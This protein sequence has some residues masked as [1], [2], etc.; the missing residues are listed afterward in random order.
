MILLGL[1]SACVEPPSGS[2]MDPSDLGADMRLDPDMSEV[3]DEDMTGNPADLGDLDEG[4]LG[5]AIGSVEILAPTVPFA[6]ETTE[7][8]AFS[9]SLQVRDT[10]GLLVENY[11]PEVSVLD[12]LVAEVTSEDDGEYTLLAIAPG[13][14]KLIITVG[15]IEASL[16]ITV[17][18]QQLA[19]IQFKQS[20][21][22]LFYD[23]Q[24]SILEEA[25]VIAL[26]EKDLPI[27]PFP[28]TACTLAIEVGNPRVLGVFTQPLG[29]TL[30][31][32]GISSW[33]ARCSNKPELS[34][35]SMVLVE[36]PQQLDAMRSHSCMR[37]DDEKVRCWGLNDHGQIGDG[38]FKDALAPTLIKTFE[39][40]DV[41]PQNISVGARHTCAISQDGDLYC[42][43]DNRFGQVDPTSDETSFPNPTL[44]SP[45]E[46]FVSVA[47]GDT[48]SCAISTRGELFC[49][50][51]GEQGQLGLGNLERAETLKKVS[52]SRFLRLDAGPT[53][54]CAISF[55]NQL[56][57][58]GDDLDGKLGNSAASS[59]NTP[60][61]I[62]AKDD[63][64][65]AVRFA[66]VAVG[67]VT[68]CAVPV[69]VDSNAP[70]A[71]YCWGRGDLF[72]NGLGN[73][74][75]SPPTPVDAD[76]PQL[77]SWRENSMG[78]GE[79]IRGV[80]V[81]LHHG[82]ALRGTKIYCW[83]SGNHG[84]L[85]LGDYGTG[86]TLIG[87]NALITPTPRRLTDVGNPM[88]DFSSVD[89]LAI[90]TGTYHSCALT[91]TE[92]LICW[93]FAGNG[94]L[95]DGKTGIEPF[96]GD[97]PSYAAPVQGMAPGREHLCLHTNS[98][99]IFC[100][101]NNFYLQSRDTPNN[102]FLVN[103]SMTASQSGVDG[104]IFSGFNPGRIYAGERF[105]IALAEGTNTPVYAW[106]ANGRYE[107]SPTR[108]S[109]Y[110]L[111][112]AHP[113]V[114]PNFRNMV[115]PITAGYAHVCGLEKMNDQSLV[116]SCWGDNSIGQLGSAKSSN[117]I[118]PVVGLP[119]DFVTLQMDA[120]DD[121]TCIIGYSA[122]NGMNPDLYCWGKD[123]GLWGIPEVEANALTPKLIASFPT[124]DFVRKISVG[125]G[126]ACILTTT[127]QVQC[128]GR[129][130]FHQAS[131]DEDAML[132]TP[133][134]VP[135]PN[136]MVFT[137]V[138][139]GHQ[140]TCA[141]TQKGGDTDFPPR[142]YVYCWGDNRL[143][144]SGMFGGVLDGDHVRT[145]PT[146]LEP[147]NMEQLMP[148][149]R[150]GFIEA[151][152][153]T[154]CVMS[155]F[156][157][158]NQPPNYRAH[159]WGNNSHGQAHQRRREDYDVRPPQ[160]SVFPTIVGAP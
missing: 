59:T 2:S 65:K 7:Q 57:C 60:V 123:V 24:G 90:T 147:P 152:W 133:T 141:L 80:A 13:T 50:G 23:P 32:V 128:W 126:H 6:L 97:S 42:W 47:A 93:G 156:N 96:D 66:S 34:D 52:T 155:Q 109:T 117:L 51:T 86:T 116:L 29:I 18:P 75:T 36:R 79:A 9:L 85:G 45:E 114:S 158:L 87:N 95:A 84:Q 55:E 35:T 111:P 101:G 125:G 112:D 140:H 137:D 38:T 124:S 106:G 43:G 102:R 150:P 1:S 160:I 12:T 138:S 61:E 81:A 110:A 136:G 78:G 153:A 64:N 58:W 10:E 69:E 146:L 129:N 74:M 15:G 46:R 11:E 145:E 54:T 4:D 107:T 70:S 28:E 132:A 134:V 91:L 21:Y 68:T 118:E 20:V 130:E 120:G 151:G 135:T 108:N 39:D 71:L 98:D 62:G 76:H 104:G 14:T 41:S 82:C 88:A 144:Q 30:S 99:T 72:A 48:H 8:V 49:W 37:T 157:D 142:Q 122:A 77:V 92:Q 131:P 127:G 89:F 53:H 17:E 100:F 159:C 3:A 25:D 56:Y 5:R 33:T 73:A 27:E 148:E 16:D 31:D 115:E 19:A 103:P 94:R 121:V 105:T 22:R 67:E 139:T 63:E 149:W 143:G 119:D 154:T 44:V 83:G 40:L 26:S 113:K